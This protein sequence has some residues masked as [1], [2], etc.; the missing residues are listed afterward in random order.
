MY[1]LF[2]NIN[3]LSLKG[4]KDNKQYDRRSVAFISSICFY[5][6]MKCD[7]QE[8]GVSLNSSLSFM[9]VVGKYS[10]LNFPCL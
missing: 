3:L 7:F 6:E 8:L 5:H 9:S 2:N 10:K 1:V 4:R